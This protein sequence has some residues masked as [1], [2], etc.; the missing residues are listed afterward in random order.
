MATQVVG[1]KPNEETAGKIRALVDVKHKLK[2]PTKE[3]VA[4][5]KFS[6]YGFVSN[7]VDAVNKE[8]A[9]SERRIRI[10][11][12][13]YDRLV[14]PNA[15]PTATGPAAAVDGPI[16]HGNV[17]AEI[18]EGKGYMLKVNGH[19]VGSPLG[20]GRADVIAAWLSAALRS[21]CDAM[22]L[23]PQEE[24]AADDF[25]PVPEVETPDAPF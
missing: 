18:V 24:T 16:V 7:M 20:R 3:K 25:P 9:L 10:I 21:I 23:Q 1:E 8:W 15:Q 22:R 13:L 11:N 19:E 6:E 5:G 17:T 14:A 4:Q 12:K 2:N